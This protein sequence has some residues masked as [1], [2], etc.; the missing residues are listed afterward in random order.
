MPGRRLGNVY[1]GEVVLKLNGIS[2]N[3]IGVEL[4]ISENY[5]NLIERM[6]FSLT[7]IE[8]GVATFDLEASIDR[9][10]TFQYGVRL[11]PKNEM[12]PHRLDFALLKWI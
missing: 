4:I 5:H 6:E 9:P 12:L 7:K 3:D 2:Q 1:K 8:D 11:F 10:G